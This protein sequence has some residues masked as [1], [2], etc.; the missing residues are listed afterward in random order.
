MQPLAR[1][2]GIASIRSSAAYSIL[3]V[4]P[5]FPL[6]SAADVAPLRLSRA[7]SDPIYMFFG[8]T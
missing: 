4:I 1:A 2:A 3:Q 7:Q 5:L 8:L 6:W